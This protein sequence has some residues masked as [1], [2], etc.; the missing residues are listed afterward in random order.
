MNSMSDVKYDAGND[1]DF[2]K[3]LTYATSCT[4]IIPNA[5]MLNRKAIRR[6]PCL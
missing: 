2:L 3:D 6:G 4:L 5:I 1:T